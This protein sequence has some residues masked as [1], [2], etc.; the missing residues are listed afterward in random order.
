MRVV[1]HGVGKGDGLG[2]GGA[3]QAAERE[4]ACAVPAPPRT[5]HLFRECA[6]PSPRPRAHLLTCRPRQ[7]YPP[8]LGAFSLSSSFRALVPL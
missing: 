6:F 7:T 8:P 5:T 3:L 2:K 4:P 1:V